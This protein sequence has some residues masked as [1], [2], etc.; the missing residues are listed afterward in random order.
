MIGV[1]TQ[2]VALGLGM[3]AGVLWPRVPQALI[4]RDTWINIG[5]GAIL[6]PV[7]LL[8][9]LL[10][11]SQ[12]HVGLLPLGSLYHPA[13]QLIFSFILL[14]FCRYWLHR[15]H[16]RVPWFWNFHRVHHSTETM[17][18]TAGLRMHLVDFVQL[19]LLPVLLFG[20]LLDTSQFAAW[21][22]PAVMVP[23]VLFDA[24]EHGNI[25][26]SLENPLARAWHRV[27][28]NPL[29]HSWHHTRD[30]ARCDGNYGNV[31]V[32]WDRL[33]ASDVTGPQPPP[34]LGLEHQRL[35]IDVLPMQLL[36]PEQ[37]P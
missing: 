33:F 32:I 13:V 15:M 22:L 34:L 36:R 23:G 26:F 3:G 17:D 20:V 16:H 35:D 14:D 31:L 19:S 8:L 10:G 27:L 25:R 1:L 21:V 30:G 28:N 11:V 18:A 12:I 37:A 5:T 6:F 9:T 2:V 24:F 29:F 7:R 4:R